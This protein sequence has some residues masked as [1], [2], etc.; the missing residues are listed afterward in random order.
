V[1]TDDFL[2]RDLVVAGH[3]LEVRAVFA[4]VHDGHIQSLRLRDKGGVCG[5]VQLNNGLSKPIQSYSQRVTDNHER[6]VTGHEFHDPFQRPAVQLKKELS[7]LLVDRWADPVSEFDEQSAISHDTKDGK[8][9]KHK[10]T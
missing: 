1:E 7:Y 5:E 3:P 2:W 4:A 8:F 10:N 9:I 6:S